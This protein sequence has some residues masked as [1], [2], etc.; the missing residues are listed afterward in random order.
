MKDTQIKHEG[1]PYELFTFARRHRISVT[2]ARR[3]IEQYG[4]DRAGADAAAKE[5]AGSAE[6]VSRPDRE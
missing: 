1:Q 5:F 4:S 2:L 6:G 3:I